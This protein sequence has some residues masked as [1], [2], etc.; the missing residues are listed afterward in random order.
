MWM[1]GWMWNANVDEWM[2]IVNVDE[3]M[4]VECKCGCGMWT[5]GCGGVDVECQ[6]GCVDECEMSMWMCGCGLPMWMCGWMWNAN[7]DAECGRVDVDE[8]M[9]NVDINI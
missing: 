9:W 3:W 2:W 8:W 1:S 5:R 6:C 4:D 7:V